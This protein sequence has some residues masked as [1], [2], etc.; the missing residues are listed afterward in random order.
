MK[1]EPDERFDLIQAPADIGGEIARRA[2]EPE[3][4][5]ASIC[6]KARSASSRQLFGVL[7]GAGDDE[8]DTMLRTIGGRVDDLVHE[9]ADELPGPRR[10]APGRASGAPRLRARVTAPAR[11]RGPRG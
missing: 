1:C 5:G 4:A 2:D 9:G 10:S 7:L 8:R 11:Q 6:L 3:K